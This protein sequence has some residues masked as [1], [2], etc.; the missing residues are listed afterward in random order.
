MDVRDVCALVSDWAASGV[1][2]VLSCGLTMITAVARGGTEPR[3]RCQKP[4]QYLPSR[5]QV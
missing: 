4:C 5:V 2:F 1:L 3:T